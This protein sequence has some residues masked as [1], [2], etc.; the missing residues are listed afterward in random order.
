VAIFFSC[1]CGQNLREDDN[2]AGGHTRCPACGLSVRVPG[3]RREDMGSTPESPHPVPPFPALEV[4]AIEVPGGPHVL[5]PP[6]S[7]ARARAEDDVYPL[8]P[9][10]HEPG[11][12]E[13]ESRRLSARAGRHSKERRGLWRNWTLE[14]HW[15]E[16]LA[17]PVRALP[18]VLILSATM[19]TL[20][21][22]LSH[23]M[24]DGWGMTEIVAHAPVLVPVL[25]A[26]FLVLGY[27]VAFLQV[28]YEAASD[29]KAGFV[30]WPGFDMR[31]TVR[32]GVQ[33]LLGF[34]AGPVVPAAG[35]FLFWLFSGEPQALQWLVL[36]ALALMT[37]AYW[38][39][40]LLS[41]QQTNRLRDLHPATVVK[42]A[43][44]FGFRAVL[45]AV[46]IALPVVG[47]VLRTLGELESPWLSAAGWLILALY[48]TGQM[49]WMVLFLRLFGVMRFRASDDAVSVRS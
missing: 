4:R 3:P 5:R 18:H 27:T 39:L 31:A 20:I 2:H 13:R 12:P 48:W 1:L 41:V 42:V 26:G 45:T 22:I 38:A 21:T 25:L 46:V 37:V 16:F 10:L 11:A 36:W 44:Q 19:A 23:M 8:L 43:R 29:G 32:S 6:Q 9:E 14:R 40:A 34:L 33:G 15:P 28:T 35:G 30:A 17:Y 47:P 49:S 7:H 24:R